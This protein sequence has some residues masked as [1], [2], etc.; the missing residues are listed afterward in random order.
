MTL[1]KEPLMSS[2]PNTLASLDPESTPRPSDPP[3]SAVLTALA[4]ALALVFLTRLPVAR[5]W[6]MD[7]D[8]LGFLGQIRVHWFPMHHTLFM[9]LG[10]LLGMLTGDAY[11]GFIVLDMVMSGLALVSVW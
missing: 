7:S 8:E 3:L 1:G 6:A 9:A 4:I 11:R 2:T 10:R 5:P